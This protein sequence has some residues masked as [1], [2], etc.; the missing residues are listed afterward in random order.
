MYVC[1]MV[2]LGCFALPVAELLYEMGKKRI[3][4]GLAVI[5][6]TQKLFTAPAV[7]PLERL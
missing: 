7:T 6:I 2:D 5:K 4:T 3:I 1:C